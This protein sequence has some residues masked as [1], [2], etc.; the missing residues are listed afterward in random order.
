METILHCSSGVLAACFWHISPYLEYRARHFDLFS[1]ISYLLASRYAYGNPSLIQ[2]QT[3]ADVQ[4][5]AR[6]LHS[7]PARCGTRCRQTPLSGSAHAALR[8]IIW[9]VGEGLEAI[10]YSGRL[11]RLKGAHLE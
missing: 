11:Y 3:H 2:D 4:A 8:G 9:G 5:V 10:H 7:F 6:T 1:S